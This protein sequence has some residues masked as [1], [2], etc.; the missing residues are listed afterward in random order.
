MQILDKSFKN[1]LSYS[2]VLFRFLQHEGLAYL[3]LLGGGRF[4]GGFLGFF[5]HNLGGNS[6]K[7]SVSNTCDASSTENLGI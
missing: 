7:I 5:I 6:I 3:F 2:V 1:R 4:L